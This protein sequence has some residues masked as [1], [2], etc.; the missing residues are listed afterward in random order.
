MGNLAPGSV[1]T[2]SSA[3]PPINTSGNFWHTCLGGGKQMLSTFSYFPKKETPK[4][5]NLPGGR[6]VP[7]IVFHPKS[8]FFCYLKP[9]A[10]FRNPMITP[11]GRKVKQEEIR[12]KK[13]R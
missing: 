4:K 13:C 9:H 1:H 12:K 8:Y 7:Q 5:S 3:Q 2:G 10:K 6:G 11:S